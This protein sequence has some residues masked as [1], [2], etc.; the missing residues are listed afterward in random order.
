MSTGIGIGLA[1]PHCRLDGIKKIRA[2]VALCPQGVDDY[3]SLDNKK[4]QIIIM[5]LAGRHQQTEYIQVLS[6]LSSKLKD[7]SFRSRLLA[8]K[9]PQDAISI[10]TEGK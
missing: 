8:V 4:V 2:A 10:I 9:T 3:V 1:I 6:L 5:I 7:E